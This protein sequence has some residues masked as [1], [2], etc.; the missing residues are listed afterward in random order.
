MKKKILI[1]VL[2]IYA[3]LVLIAT[4]ALLDR[5]E[6]GVY[7]TGS[8]YYYSGEIENYSSSSLLKFEKRDNLDDLIDKDVYY[9][10]N[11]KHLKQG[12]LSEYDTKLETVTVDDVKYG[13]KNYLGVVSGETKVIGSI[14]NVLTS[15]GFYFVFVIIPIVIL[16]MFEIYLLYIYASH[17][18]DGKD[19]DDD[20][21]APKKNK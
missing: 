13:M 21:K 14:L 17:N 20:K 18:K 1:V 4:K 3:L 8:N 15:K 5:N 6:F 11:E 19:N 12:K 10:D 9:F 7:E 2:V 16:F